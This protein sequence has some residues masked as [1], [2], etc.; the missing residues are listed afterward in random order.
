MAFL[1]DKGIGTPE[2]TTL[3]R[4]ICRKLTPT[5]IMLRG[6]F[7]VTEMAAEEIVSLPMFPTLS[8]EQQAQVVKQVK[9]FVESARKTSLPEPVRLE[10]V[11]RTS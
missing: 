6:D 8:S 10:T 11:G 5:L 4:C 7:P 1:K 9:S 3:S 2:F